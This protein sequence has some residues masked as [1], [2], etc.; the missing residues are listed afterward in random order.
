MAWYSLFVLKVP[1]NNNKQTNKQTSK[2]TSAPQPRSITRQT[3][4]EIDVQSKTTIN[5]GFHYKMR[6]HA[7]MHKQW[8]LC[9]RLYLAVQL[10]H[11]EI[12]LSSRFAPLPLSAL[13]LLVGW[14]EGHPACKKLGV[15]L[16]VLTIWPELCT[17]YSSS[18]HRHLHH[19]SSNKIQ[20]EDILVSANPDPPGKWPLIWSESR[21]ARF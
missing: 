2:V 11:I 10:F 15:G 21:F 20:N 7:E 1:L 12:M 13:T 18:C 14:Q 4:V 19:L 17:S 6:L 8:S 3:C 9:I 5:N 16:L